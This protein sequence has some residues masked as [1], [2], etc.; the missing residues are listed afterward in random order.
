VKPSDRIVPAT[1]L[2]WN[3]E[4]EAALLMAEAYHQAMSEIHQNACPA[5]MVDDEELHRLYAEAP[6]RAA[7]IRQELGR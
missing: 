5:D 4:L 6:K 1:T 3:V 7:A 2:W